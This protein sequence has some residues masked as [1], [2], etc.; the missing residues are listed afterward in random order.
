MSA[1]SGNEVS[2]LQLTLHG[3]SR[4]LKDR[5]IIVSHKEALNESEIPERLSVL[6]VILSKLPSE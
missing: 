6:A 5:L 3:L 1:A 2:V 4:H